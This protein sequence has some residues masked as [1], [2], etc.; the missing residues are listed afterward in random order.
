M[1]VSVMIVVE[2]ILTLSKSSL[3]TTGINQDP[4]PLW[5][6]TPN[7]W[8]TP[9]IATSSKAEIV[10]GDSTCCSPYSPPFASIPYNLATDSAVPDPWLDPQGMRLFS[11]LF[12]SSVTCYNT[13]LQWLTDIS[14]YLHFHC[15]S[16][17]EPLHVRCGSYLHEQV[18]LSHTHIRT[19][20]AG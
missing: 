12:I 19:I 5:T 11:G 10:S 20:W 13:Q 18:D 1:S 17:N 4:I 6:F 2:T 9:V 8:S 3:I 14:E 15:E 7:I 16:L